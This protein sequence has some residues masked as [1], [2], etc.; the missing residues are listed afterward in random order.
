MCNYLYSSFMCGTLI[1]AI[2]RGDG[3]IEHRIDKVINI[4]TGRKTF[5]GCMKKHTTLT[6]LADQG[7]VYTTVRFTQSLWQANQENKYFLLSLNSHA[8][9]W[10]KVTGVLNGPLPTPLMAATLNICSMSS[11]V[12]QPSSTHSS[13][14]PSY[15]ALEMQG[16]VKSEMSNSIA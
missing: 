2:L 9:F 15:T 13:V 4:N 8:F 5:T 14:E 12:V 10:V 16:I 11:S 3:L 7:T 1:L 6:S